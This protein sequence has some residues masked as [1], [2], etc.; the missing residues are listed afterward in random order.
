MAAAS[1]SVSAG[2]LDD[3]GDFKTVGH[4]YVAEAGKYYRIDDG[5]P[6]LRTGNGGAGG[7]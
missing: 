2:S 1:M 7:R 4:V 5:L 6:Q 3:S